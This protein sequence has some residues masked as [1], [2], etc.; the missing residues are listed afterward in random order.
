[1]LSNNM[2]T[3]CCLGNLSGYQNTLQADQ[4]D[5]QST[6]FDESLFWSMDLMMED[7]PPQM[8]DL[9]FGADQFYS[10]I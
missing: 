7:F 8:D 5:L 3:D 4:A 10:W 1:M 6:S 9:L 2:L